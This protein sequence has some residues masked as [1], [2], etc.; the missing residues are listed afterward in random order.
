[1]YPATPWKLQG[2]ELAMASRPAEHCMAGRL[3]R[4]VDADDVYNLGAAQEDATDLRRREP[5]RPGLLQLCA[6][7]QIEKVLKAVP[8]YIEEL[9]RALPAGSS[10]KG[11][12]TRR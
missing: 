1:M 10:A 7:E 9:N 2:G 6:K 8:A 11:D 3:R 5:V 12:L 4:A